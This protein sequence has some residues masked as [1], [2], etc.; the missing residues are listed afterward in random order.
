M[1]KALL[2]LF[3][4]AALGTGA[5]LLFFRTKPLLVKTTPVR[6][7]PV[8]ENVN[9]TSAGTVKPRKEVKVNAELPGRID[10][11]HHR[12]GDT[13]KAGE[14]MIDLARKS[15]EAQV[16]VAEANVTVARSQLESARL[17]QQ[18]ALD[19][20]KRVE[21]LFNSHPDDRFVSASEHE[22][23]RNEKE[24]AEEGVRM[25]ESNLA[26]LA[27]QR[28]VVLADL[29]KTRITAPFAGVITRLNVEEGGA[30]GMTAPLFELL[31]LSTLH[32]LAPFDEVDIGKVKL[33]QVARL[34]V[35]A[36]PGRT[37]A[38]R[39]IEILPVV[40][41]S[42]SK[43]RTVDVK[44][45]LDDQEEHFL[46]GM[47]VDVTIVTGRKEDA[48]FLPT[49]SIKNAQFVYV[50]DAGRIRQRRITL[51]LANWETTEARAGVA[52]GERVV[53]LL[54]LDEPGDLEGR[55]AASDERP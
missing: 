31:D 17:R 47:S 32:V 16:A 27:A 2:V 28:Q 37:F 23:A 43:N 9:G 45:A 12:E 8:E 53:S 18:K 29:D 36:F 26:Q 44:V 14:P 24:L 4:L 35:D 39:V 5:K 41:S 55:E 20:F 42:Q 46:V 30:A 13:V 50:L 7:G 48:L 19:D 15:L 21:G 10:R 40:N 49:K 38:S 3:L 25:A 22:R 6:K 34:A 51:G 54:D 1:K 33:G 52:E 11:I